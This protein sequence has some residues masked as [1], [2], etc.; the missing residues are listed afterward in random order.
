[1]LPKGPVVRSKPIVVCEESM[2]HN[3]FELK[4]ARFAIL[5]TSEFK[6]VGVNV[7]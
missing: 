2:G 4:P 3:L 6:K 7:R 5:S 1:M